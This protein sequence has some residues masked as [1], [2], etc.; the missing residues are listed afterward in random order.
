MLYEVYDIGYVVLIHS[1]IDSSFINS[2]SL[3]N[4]QEE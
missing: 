3:D 2:L 1:E 4:G